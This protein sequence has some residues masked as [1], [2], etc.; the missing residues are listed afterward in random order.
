MATSSSS[1]RTALQKNFF[2]LRLILVCI[3]AASVGLPIALISIAKILLFIG[4]AALLLSGRRPAGQS[5]AESARLATPAVVLAVLAVFAVSLAWTTADESV[6]LGSMVKYGKLLLIPLIALLL[7]TRREAMYACAAFAIAQVFRLASSWM[8]FMHVPVAWTTS[9]YAV[10]QYAVFSSYLDEGLMSAVLAALCW[11][12]RAFAPGRFGPQ[13]AVA[14]A[15]LSLAQVFFVFEGRSGHVVAVVLLSLAVLWR[16]PPKVRIVAGLLPVV[17]M[18][19]LAAVSPKVQNRI[20]K[21]QSEIQAFSFEKGQDFKTGTSSGI[22]LHLWHRAVQSIGQSPFWGSGVGSW[23][24]EFNRI[25]GENL[26][27]P[28]KTTEMGNPHQEYLQWGV[29]LGVPGVLLLAWLMF[30]LVRDT[31]AMP[32][33][34]AHAIQSTVAALAVA[35]LFNSSL[36]DALIGDFFCV[37]L[38]LL[39]ALGLSGQPM[40][41]PSREGARVEPA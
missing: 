18:V 1:S 13:I 10:S 16:L 36:Y 22:R 29:Q 5:G 26:T 8:L 20:A 19:G 3:A 12:L 41:S 30:Y 34:V 14:V 4:G 6:A 31:R 23:S 7:R 21:T 39:L 32:R 24:K 11:H 9:S 40:D 17:F 28:Q 2:N 33:P 35:C 15:L 27:A 25:D 37:T 38:G